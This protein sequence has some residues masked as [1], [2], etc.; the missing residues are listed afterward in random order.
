MSTFKNF[1]NKFV[2]RHNMNDTS[3]IVVQPTY[4]E[5]P[6]YNDADRGD[7]TVQSI[8]ESVPSTKEFQ[9]QVHLKSTNLVSLNLV[10]RK[11]LNDIYSWT[12]LLRNASGFTF[13]TAILGEDGKCSVVCTD[14]DDVRNLSASCIF[15]HIMKKICA[16][17]RWILE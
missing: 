10:E 14:K 2:R 5:V 16:L 11:C 4:D 7:E 1:V 13:A 8:Y 15:E 12:F 6:T 9:L 17:F 3:G